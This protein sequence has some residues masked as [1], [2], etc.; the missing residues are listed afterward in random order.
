MKKRIILHV[1]VNNAFLSWTAVDM[2]NKG[3]KV[4]IRN[5]FSVIGG[6][7]KQRRGI[8]LAKSNPAKKMGVVTAES[9]YM[10]RKKCPNLEVYPP[11][12]NLYAKFSDMLYNYLT[13][14][15]PLVERYS[16]DECF[17]DY[18]GCEN[19]FGDAFE[20]AYKIK[21]EIKEKFG[22]TV[23]VGVGN[24]KLC[25]KMASDFSKPD[26]VHTLFLDEVKTKMWPLDVADLFMIGKKTALKLKE[27]GIIKI[28]D[29]AHADY[30]FLTRHF[31]NMAKKMIEFANG[32]DESEVEGE[33]NDLKSISCSTVLPF[34]YDNME[35][36]KKVIRKLTF[37]VGRRLRQFNYFAY[38]VGVS[39]KYSNFSKVSK[40]KQ[41]DR[42]VNSDSELY[43]LGVQLF[44]DLWNKEAVRNIAFFVT[45]FTEK[46][47]LQLSL[48]DNNEII[49][50]DNKLQKTID[51]LRGKYGNEKI[52][53]GDMIKK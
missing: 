23:N 25:A 12:Y 16:V 19:L 13:T 7:E 20:V 33:S 24:N 31:K 45:N 3:H 51:E 28:F 9:L 38:V 42:N 36:I 2:L 41:L 52:I 5:R 22:F 14:Y 46:A 37:D 17:V 30:E 53:Y 34:D 43:S 15:S 35:D 32:I 49:L 47:N 10:A 44:T 21:N 18:T 4:D 11:D 48:F 1:D 6:D 39:I 26:K 29:L 8:V 27:F 40:Q 50:S